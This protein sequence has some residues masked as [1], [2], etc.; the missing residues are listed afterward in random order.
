MT[1]T[2]TA[3][4]VGTVP[5][6]AR[7]G[8]LLGCAAVAGPLFVVTFAVQALTREGFEIAQHPL[9]VLSLG[10]HGWIQV[11]NFLTT[12]VLFVAGAVG[13][14]RAMAGARGSRWAPRLIGTFGAALILAG[15]FA[16]DP[17]DGYPVGTTAPADPSWH[18]IVHSLAPAIA[19]LALSAAC[20]VFARYFAQRADRRRAI[21]SV[22]VGLAMFAPDALLGTDGFLVAVAVAIAVGWTWASYVALHLARGPQSTEQGR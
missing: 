15:L 18:S 10:E 21:I 19:F 5:V 13:L 3:T 2:T 17:V 11:A 7:T 20:F 16:A 4:G 12:G 22:A 6:A 1:I 9:S 14:R 8:R